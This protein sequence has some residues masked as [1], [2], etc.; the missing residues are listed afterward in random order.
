[1]VDWKASVEVTLK[2][3]NHNRTDRLQFLSARPT[4]RVAQVDPI[5]HTADPWYELNKNKDASRFVKDQM[6]TVK[7]PI[8]KK[9]SC[10]LCPIPRLCST[11]MAMRVYL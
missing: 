2:N 4:G 11:C 1:M 6:V 5:K 8:G 3:P 9:R 7:I 10:R